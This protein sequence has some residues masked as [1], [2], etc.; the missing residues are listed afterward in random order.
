[1]SRHPWPADENPVRGD[2]AEVIWLPDG[3]YI[4]A[5]GLCGYEGK[6]QDVHALARQI[7]RTHTTTNRHKAQIRKAFGRG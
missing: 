2:P 6:P 3:R 7:V 4:P 5:C 1:M